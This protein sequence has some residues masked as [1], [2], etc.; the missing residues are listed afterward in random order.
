MQ[1]WLS[2][3]ILCGAVAAAH[4]TPM[5]WVPAT[6]VQV[7]PERARIT[8]DHARIDSIGMAPMVMP[9]KVDRSVD[10]RRFQA[11][12]KVRFQLASPDGQ[13]QVQA[14]EKTP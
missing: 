1:R 14:L 11:G 4:A 2:A 12:D 7:A 6:V 5:E 13:L 9:F 3:A 10:L 8:L